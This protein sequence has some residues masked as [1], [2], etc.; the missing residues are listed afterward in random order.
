MPLI[1]PEAVRH[2]AVVGSGTIG[3]SWAA[4]FLAHGYDVTIDDPQPS[5]E[6]ATRDLIANAWQVAIAMMVGTASGW[7]ASPRF[8]RWLNGVT[9][10]VLDANGGE[11]FPP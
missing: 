6:A 1:A 10:A 5:A 3:A 2:I 8:A 11:T 4:L 9:G 7:L